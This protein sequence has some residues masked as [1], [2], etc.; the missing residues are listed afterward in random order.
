MDPVQLDE[1]DW[2]ACYALHSAA[3]AERGSRPNA[4]QAAYRAGHLSLSSDGQQLFW[5]AREDDRIIGKADLYLGDQLTDRGR[6]ALYV[7]AEHRRRGTATELLRALVDAALSRGCEQLVVGIDHADS[8]TLCEQ[9]GGELT[10]RVTIRTLALNDVPWPRVDTWVEAGERDS[11][12]ARVLQFDRLPDE[13]AGDYLRLMERVQA[14]VPRA[15]TPVPSVSLDVRRAEE[16]AYARRGW[17]WHCFALQEPDGTLSALAEVSHDPLIADG[18][19]HQI[20]GV[21]P[22]Q[23][24][25]GRAKW[26][27]AAVLKDICTRYPQVTRVTTNNADDNGP[28]VSINR[29]LG[30]VDRVQQAI[31]RFDAAG[32]RAHLG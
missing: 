32:F 10:Q 8:R 31:Y 3:H 22:A 28:M 18:V 20:T 24:G 30:F 9:A 5:V 15:G 12:G 4:S 2:S 27:K 6:F 21:A 11:P 26:I 13:L 7:L 17:R 19:H 23:R 25:R 16:L 29:Q 14:D 1:A